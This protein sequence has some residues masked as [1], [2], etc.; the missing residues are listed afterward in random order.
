[1]PSDERV[2]H[3]ESWNSICRDY[4]RHF[5]ECKLW[6]RAQA[7]YPVWTCRDCYDGQLPNPPITLFTD[8]DRAGGRDA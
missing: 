3:K 1:M 6:E 2:T 5:T 4:D 7:I 8:G